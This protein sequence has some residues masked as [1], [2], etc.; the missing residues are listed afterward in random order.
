MTSSIAPA[1]TRPRVLFIG[2]DSSSPQI[3]AS[4]LSQVAED[5][6]RVATAGTQP[7]DPGGRSDEMLVAMGLNPADEHRVSVHS[8][9]HADRVVSLGVGLDVARV[10]GAR[11]EEWDLGHEDLVVH[12]EELSDDLLAPSAVEPEHSV[13][14]RVRSWLGSARR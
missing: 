9:N 14:T 2:H 13:L 10:G 5:R 12:V 6:V 8:L 4:L 3:A 1:D 7:A 11:Y